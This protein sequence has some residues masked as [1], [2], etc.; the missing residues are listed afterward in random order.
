M[1]RLL[2]ATLACSALLLPA[3][4]CY[5]YDARAKNLTSHDV[6]VSIHKGTRKREVS[7]AVLASGASVGWN[8][9]FNG[10]V[11][12]RVQSGGE[13]VD[14]DLPRRAHTMVE[15]TDGGG[16]LAV[17]KTIG[18][19]SWTLGPACPED[20]EEAC[21]AEPAEDSA[22]GDDEMVDLVE[23]GDG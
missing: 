10:P 8:G 11:W 16:E 19:E 4:G 17:I 20:C 3:S 5:R 12:V 9:S 1:P 23:P 13:M 7:T 2:L 6:R 22:G 15:V 14:V 18:E 21:C